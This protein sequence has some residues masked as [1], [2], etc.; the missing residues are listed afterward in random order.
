MSTTSQPRAPI[1]FRQALQQLSSAQKPPAKGSPAYSRFVNRRIGR[2]LA[3]AAVPM[4]LTPN[5]VTGI[6]AGFSATAIALIALVRPGVGTGLAVAGLLVLGYAFD[7]ADGQLARFRG[8]GSPAG[9]WLDHVVDSVK[10]SALHLAVLIAWFRHFGLPD[11]ALLVPIGFTLVSAVLFFVQILTDQLRRAHPVDAPG[12]ADSSPRAV[13]RSVVVVPTD[14]GLLCLSFGLLGY[15]P[16]FVV[17]YSLMF[18]AS[19]AFLLA[20][21]PKWFREVGRYGSGEAR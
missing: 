10:V 21:L 11:G 5:Q 9:E 3:A 16:G 20:A 6:S 19:S 14:Y 17:V 12:R 4:G 18:A 1:G 7:S 8:G 13:L 15:Q 2:V